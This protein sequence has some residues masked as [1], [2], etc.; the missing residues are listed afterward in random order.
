[1]SDYRQFF[2]KAK[3]VRKDDVAIQRPRIKKKR[4]RRPSQPFPLTAALVLSGTLAGLGFYLAMPEK[5]EELFSKIEIHAVG[6]AGAEEKKTAEKNTSKNP[7]TAK[8]AAATEAKGN[9]DEGHLSSEELSHYGKLRQ[10]KEELDLREKELSQLEEELQRQKVELDRR[11]QQLEALRGEIAQILKERVEV[12]QEKVGKLVDFYSNMKPKQAAEIIGS[13]NEDLA[14]EV[15]ARMK[16]KNAAEI[17]N[18][19]S[20]EKAKVLSEKYTGYR[21]NHEDKG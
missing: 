1:M 4:T 14:V 12:D 10:R 6:L 5:V 8:P 20:P 15:L 7:G 19:L 21:R 17:M 13:L 3:E 16:K 11:I 2:K 9:P 18:L